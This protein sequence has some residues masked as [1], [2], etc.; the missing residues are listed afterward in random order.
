M[1]DDQITRHIDI[2]AM[3][4][5]VWRALIDPVQ[6][7]A[8]F[9]VRL[10]GPF[11]VG[12]TTTG[13]MTYPGHEDTPWTSVTEVIEPAR[14]LVFRWPHLSPDDASVETGWTLVSFVLEPQGD[15]TRV[16]VT[17]SGFSALPAAQRDSAMRGN[18]EGWQIQ[19]GNLKAH[20]E[21]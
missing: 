20:V 6:F 1:A 5:A 17:E 16:T 18:A 21:A 13:S 12:E 8:W 7:G 15:G 11:I 9:R 3:P 2:D 14:R 19:A 4:D 10:D